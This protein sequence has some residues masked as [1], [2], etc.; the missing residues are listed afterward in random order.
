MFKKIL[1]ANRGEIA[2][3]IAR[4]V[5]EMGIAAVAVY[6][7]A[8]RR[9]PHVLACDE[10]SPLPG[11]TSAETYLR[12][13]AIIAIAQQHGADAI[14][15]GFGFLAENAE[16]AEACAGAGITFI[17]PS[18]EAIAAMGDKIIAK[19]MMK[20]AGVPCV[21]GWTDGG[22]VTIEQAQ[23]HAGAIGYPLLVKAAAGGGGKGMRIVNEPDE[24]EAAFD[25]ARREAA[26]A[27][28]DGRV[29]LEKYVPRAR[30]IEF[31]IFGDAHGKV[32]HL[33]ERECS[34]QRRHQKIIEESPSPGFSEH[35]RQRMGKAAVQAARTLSYTNAG[36]VEFMVDDEENF[37]FLEVNTRLQVEHP[38]T[39]MTLHRDLVKAQILVAAGEPLPFGQKELK[40]EGHAIECRI[41]AEDPA[42]E[43]MPSTGVIGVYEPPAGPNVRVDSGVVAGSEV[44]VYYD[45]MLAKL[46]VWGRTRNEAI[47]RM[48]RALSRYVILGVTTNIAFL[49][50]VINHA[51]FRA[52]ELH[53]G[54]LAEH[55]IG[56]AVDDE[57]PDEAY[58]AAA[59]AVRDGGVLVGAGISGGGAE[60][61]SSG[62]GPRSPWQTGGQW[63]VV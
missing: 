62:G 8:D 27:F 60:G 56:T 7:D 42:R 32:V 16:F 54:F 45:P 43:F 30:H 55:G 40:Q 13:D 12:G 1:I 51:A 6:S 57:T 63:R 14:H 3:R 46:I 49:R 36:T 23:Q 41:Y 50:E 39:E 31:Q 28:G 53:T 37:Y 48:D 25:A 21:P 47:A 61:S 26:A 59:L 4:T 9:S 38:V 5:Q 2:L 20:K 18:P 35:L 19:E 44:S 17:G 11:N 58:I 24:L 33:F 10:A 34:I 15:P 22:D 29:F 52:G